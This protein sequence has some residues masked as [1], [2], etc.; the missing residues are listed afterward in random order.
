VTVHLVLTRS[1]L[2]LLSVTWPESH[3]SVAPQFFMSKSVVF[4]LLMEICKVLY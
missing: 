1:G 3:S 4:S 2:A